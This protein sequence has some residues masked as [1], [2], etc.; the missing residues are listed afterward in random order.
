MKKALQVLMICSF[1]LAP[2]FASAIDA[3]RASDDGSK[4]TKS[5]H[6]T[7]SNKRK[8]RSSKADQQILA[9]S[10]SEGGSLSSQEEI[11]EIR[12]GLGEK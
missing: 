4:L 9:E 7:K 1:T 6:G 12:E 8:S 3:H 10:R 2:A 11:D 5:D